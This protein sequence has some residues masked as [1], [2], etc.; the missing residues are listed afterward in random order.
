MENLKTVFLVGNGGREH[1]IAWKISQSP[2]LDKLY[3]FPGHDGIAA[4]NK[5]TCLNEDVLTAAMRLSP[6]LIIIGPEQPLAEGLTDILEDNGFHVFGPSQYAAQLESSKV[7]SKDF[8]LAHN[9]PTARHISCHTIDEA[10]DA[11]EKWD[12]SKGFVIKA[13]ALAAGKGVVVTDERDTARKTIIDFMRNP[14]CTVK[15]DKILIEEKLHGK[16]VSAFA[17]CDGE[18]FLTLGYACD[19]K[20]VFSGD[21]GPNTGGMGGY[22]PKDWPSQK[23]KDFVETHIFQ[24]T[25]DGMKQSGHPFKGILFA[26][27]MID[28][29]DVQVIEFNVRLG[30]PETQMLLPLI[31]DDLLHVLDLAAHKKLSAFGRS[32]LNL[33]QDTALHIVLAS[34]GYPSTDGTAMTLGEDIHLPTEYLTPHIND[35]QP[36][37]FLAGVKKENNTWINTGGRVLGVTALGADITTART[38]AYDAIK[39]ITFNGAHW[40]DDIGQ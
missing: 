39:N 15:T 24:K 10:L 13:D 37:V 23:V 4:L 27:L 6:D 3:I 14:D 30:D 19:Y 12:E 31:E 22:V 5:A 2:L 26:G 21:R 1:A 18:T 33:S 20:R 40:R 34:A 17:I 35:N 8:M 36:V 11:V 28:G 29:D 38:R 16:E 9:I 25:I 32:A 7:F